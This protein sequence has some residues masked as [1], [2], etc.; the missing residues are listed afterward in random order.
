MEVKSVQNRI[1]DFYSDKSDKYV[2]QGH[3]SQF[4]QGEVTTRDGKITA[5]PRT[6]ER[7]WVS[8]CE[9]HNCVQTSGCLGA[10]LHFNTIPETITI[11]P[12]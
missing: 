8:G 10:S 6:T 5:Q 7:L 9:K 12:N 4:S 3:S 2:I 1:Q 11:T